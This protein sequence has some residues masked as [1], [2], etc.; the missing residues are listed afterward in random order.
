MNRYRVDRNNEP[1]APCGMN[2]LIYLGDS[3]PAALRVFHSTKPGFDSWA[4][5][6]PKYG[7]VLS[8]WNEEKRDY[9]TLIANLPETES[10]RD[11]HL[12]SRGPFPQTPASD[13]A[14]H[15]GSPR[16]QQSHSTS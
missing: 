11:L 16:D 14:N 3:Y 2:S 10:L 4:K 8:Q 13:L 6:N 9:T 1:R 15:A 7:V 5:P 12:G